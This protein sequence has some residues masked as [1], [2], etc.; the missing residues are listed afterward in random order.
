MLNYQSEI[1]QLQMEGELS[2]DDLIASLPQELRDG[3]LQEQEESISKRYV[4]ILLPYSLLQGKIELSLFLYFC[5][6]GT[7][8]LKAAINVCFIVAL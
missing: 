4:G 5:L 2:I 1:Q 8:L 7:A 3:L 6:T